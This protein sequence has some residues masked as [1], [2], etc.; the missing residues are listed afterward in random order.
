MV[1]QTSTETN[2][3]RRKFLRVI[4]GILLAS[5]VT[6]IFGPIV[7]FFWPSDLETMPSDPVLIGDE[8]S[9]PVGGS[10]TVRFGRYP[11]IVINTSSKGLVAYSAV[12]THFACI[13]NWNQESGMIE[14][15]CHAGFYDPLDG[16]VISG[17]TPA[18]LE[19]LDVLF[20]DNKILILAVQGS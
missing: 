13:V 18:P 10:V 5:G 15:P 6:P 9:I 3:T 19:K 12:C 2:L 8:G 16:S 11:A 20:E 1:N 17:P 4:K 7:A 14:C